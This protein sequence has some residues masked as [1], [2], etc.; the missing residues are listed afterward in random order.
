LTR[1]PP[2]NLRSFLNAPVPVHSDAN[3]PDGVP[4]LAP[5]RIVAATGD[6]EMRGVGASDL[7]YFAKAARVIAGRDLVDVAVQAQ[8][9]RDT[10]LSL[11][12]AGR[13]IRYSAGRDTLGR[14]EQNLRGV[15]IEGPG[16]LQ[17]VAGRDID[18]QT[19][20]GIVTRG[21]FDNRFLPAGG[22]SV[23]V[24]AGVGDIAALDSSAAIY[25]YLVR[26]PSYAE[27]L[28]AFVRAEGAEAATLADASAAFQLLPADAQR[29][30]FAALGLALPSGT[31][32]VALLDDYLT[33]RIDF[34][35]LFLAYVRENGSGNA[36]SAT[37]AAAE[38]M[39]FDESLRSEFF[40][41]IDVTAPPG[42]DHF[43]LL[44]QNVLAPA[45]AART[46]V[47]YVNALAAADSDGDAIPTVTTLAE[48]R[49][50]FRD[51]LDAEARRA[52][53]VTLGV[54]LSEQPDYTALLDEYVVAPDRYAADL[55]TYV[56]RLGGT[57]A[58]TAGA[59]DE[60]GALDGA[61]RLAFLEPILFGE[62][63]EGGRTAA[64]AGAANGDFTRAFDALEAMF[65]GSLPDEESG[66]A[67]SFAGDIRLFFSR[68]YTLAGGD[69]NV[70][71]PGGEINVGLATPPAAFGVGKAASELGMVVQQTGSV[72]AIAYDDFQVNE[73][74]VFAADGG[75]VLVWSTE[76]DIDAGRGA[77]TA[78]S[79]PP[80]TVIIDENGKITVRFPAALTGSGIQTLATS[81]GRKPGNV[82]L[83]AP[84]GVVNAGDAGIVAGNLTI[85]ATAVLGADNISVSGV[86]VGV[87]VDTGGFAAALTGVSAVASS[88]T[89]AA[90][91]TVG[92][93]RAEETATP[94]ADQALGFLDVFVTGFGDGSTPQEQEREQE[95][96][97]CDPATDDCSTP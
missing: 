97:E 88:A 81:A 55:V 52:F 78:I 19:S 14:L 7:F 89:N 23:S 39:T 49:G 22:A 75:N 9:L 45:R 11:L 33:E 5:V 74:R 32:Y 53:F 61:R 60:F 18:L 68:L 56:R 35:A 42:A 66:E 92:P 72:S 1:T 59:L 50:V 54:E 62:I 93:S 51:T 84:R 77:K 79:A 44:E 26:R 90:E 30:F 3:Q 58:T 17:V 91:D 65:P 57:G 15:I 20:Q 21:N 37:D 38:F 63:R 41:S 4:D 67:N 47:R 40:A 36:Q 82:D 34:S 43:A 76:G 13:D 96:E 2:Q 80:P 86:S 73:S 85:A 70:M 16:L 64:K 29:E 6:V 46:L 95:E 24:L 87:P 27:V 69:I 31:D 25:E 28:M 71:A 10:D 94:L 48:A 83:F 12:Q 8:H